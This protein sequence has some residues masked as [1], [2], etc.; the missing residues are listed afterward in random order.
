MTLPK[1]A[2]LG[3]YGGPKQD[4]SA[5]IDSSTDRPAAGTNPAYGDT[6]AMTHT[7]VRAW[8]RFQPN[9]SGAQPTLPVTNAHDEMWNNGLN[10]PPVPSR[11]GPGVYPVTFPTT[12]VDEIPSNFP[13]FTGA[14]PVNF[15]SS[16]P[17]VE[18]GSTT[19][20]DVSTKV[21][22]ANV[23]TVQIFQVGTSTPVD[24]NDGTIIGVFGV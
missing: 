4:Y 13:G 21:T 2:S 10:G 20:Y 15:R 23:I 5:S 3:T 24:P 7:A 11:S 12:V 22:S 18:L 16:W 8:V 9:G 19:N 17:N 1:V 14:Q 6:A